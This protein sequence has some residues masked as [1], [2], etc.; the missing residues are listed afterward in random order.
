MGVR[1]QRLAVVAAALA[2]AAVATRLDA[3]PFVNLDFESATI[4]PGSDYL[5]WNFAAPGWQHSTGADLEGVYHGRTHYG[6]SGYYVLHDAQYR[7]T[8]APL[9]GTYSMGS[10]TRTH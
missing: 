10:R 4:V 8:F 5:D 7:F 9:A 1:G 3:A 6:G 2:G